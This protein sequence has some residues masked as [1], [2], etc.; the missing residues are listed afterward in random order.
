MGKTLRT[1]FIALAAAIVATF[2]FATVAGAEGNNSYVGNTVATTPTSVT[3]KNPGQVLS[4]TSENTPAAA[5][6][7]EV[8]S[9]SLAF[10]GSDATTLA[11]VGVVAVL[12][13]GSILVIRRRSVSSRLT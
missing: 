7:T 1:T 13:G 12:A 2:A 8:K 3:P 6:K 4:A 11:L 9:E 10:T 5:A